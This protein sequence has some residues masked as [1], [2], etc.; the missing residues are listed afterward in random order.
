MNH[1][2]TAVAGLKVGHYTDLEGTTGCT[3]II[4]SDGAVA[5]VDVR[6]GASGT[7]ETN[8][9]DP[10]N[11]VSE[12]HALM[13]GGGSA[14]GLAAAEGVIRFLLWLQGNPAKQQISPFSEPSPPMFWLKRFCGR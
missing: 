7:R 10:V 6:G 3:V 5:G 11:T 1:T 9:L 4:A 2:L 14:Y 12:I 13:I 8:L